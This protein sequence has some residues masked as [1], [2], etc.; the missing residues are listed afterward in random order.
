MKFLERDNYLQL[1]KSREATIRKT[2][3]CFSRMRFWKGTARDKKNPY[4]INK[5][6]MDDK[7]FSLQSK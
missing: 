1:I 5:D 6:F 4:S 2:N 3:C 7:F